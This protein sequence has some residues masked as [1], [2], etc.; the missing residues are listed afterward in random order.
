MSVRY[1]WNELRKLVD[2]DHHITTHTAAIAVCTQEAAALRARKPSIEEA[3]EKSKTALHAAQKE[4][5]LLELSLRDIRDQDKK[6]QRLLEQSSNPREY[7]ALEHECATLA[8]KIDV[9]EEKVC[10]ELDTI[11]THQAAYDAALAAR[12]CLNTALKEQ[13]CKTDTCTR[14]HREALET[15]AK[16]WDTQA[17]LVPEQL[18]KAYRDIRGRVPNPV[19]AIIAKSCS[20][21][22]TALLPHEAQSLTTHTVIR[23]RGCYRFLFLEHTPTPEEPAAHE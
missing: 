18:C 13:E 4:L 23:C 14:E 17:A 19:V 20:V 5:G 7:T 3:V 15:L 12:E 11:K 16:E 22:F 2:I 1:V 9:L 21:C 6:K 8:R 10:D